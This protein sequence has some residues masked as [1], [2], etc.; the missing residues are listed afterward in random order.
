LEILNITEDQGIDEKGPDYHTPY[1][2]TESEAALFDSPLPRDLPTA[3]KDL[4]ILAAAYDGNLD[5]YARLRRP[6]H[7]VDYE[8]HC[9]VH[10]VYKSTAMAHWLDRNPGVMQSVYGA[11]YS[12]GEPKELQ[13]AIHARRV[14]NNDVYHII[15]ACPPVPNDELPYWIWWP[16]LP[17]PKV[18]FKLAKKRSA[19][20]HQCVRAC[21]A[22]MRG[23][24]GKPV[25]VDR[26]LMHDAET[27]PEHRFFQPDMIQRMNEQGLQT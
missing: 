18:L 1:E 19:M 24:D 11:W 15:N 17:A 9:L 2:L 14:M 23:E 27:C 16:T 21:I 10:G 7:P 22:G 13:R 8:L 12:Y 26:V 6:G 4:M 3:H 5:R 25:A 20:R